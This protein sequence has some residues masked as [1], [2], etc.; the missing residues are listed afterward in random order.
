MFVFV[1]LRRW[2]KLTLLVIYRRIYGFGR[3][4]LPENTPIIFAMNH[5]TAFIEPTLI[6][7]LYWE[8][9]T[10]FLMS[11]AFFKPGLATKFVESCQILPI[12]RRSD[13]IEK[14]RLNKDTFERCYQ[15]MKTG[16]QHIVI[17]SEGKNHHS[18]ELLPVQKGTAKMGFESIT[19]YDME[20]VVIIPVGANYSDSLQFRSVF[21][22]EFGEP[23]KV[24]DFLPIYLEDER[25][26][27]Q[28][29][30]NEVEAKMRESII[31]IDDRADEP[32]TNILLDINR[33]PRLR[34]A[35]SGVIVDNSLLKEE[36]AIANW[37]NDMDENF[38]NT[39]WLLLFAP[40]VIIPILF[41]IPMYA[42][43]QFLNNKFI[44]KPVFQSA[45]KYGVFA[46]LSLIYYII[47]LIILGIIFGW[48]G[49]LFV[50]MMVPLGLMSMWYRDLAEMWNEGRKYRG[51]SKAK[52][53]LLEG[54]RAKLLG[55]LPV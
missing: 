45:F 5:P 32:F 10:F 24:K 27:I 36:Q 6:P 50:V 46:V 40:F 26:G 47:M 54:M 20:N 19:K 37:V 53:A 29:L 7:V 31:C 48:K 41:N 16:K 22:Y 17:L 43:T 55:Q 42:V 35:K 30:T 21:M 12:Y 9:S 4:R 39:F 49:L 1:T 23:I 44:K 34:S 25:K 28:T 14:V 11:G 3:E 18:K 38:L 33:A 2:L 51:L 15:L 8:L 52:K 13:G